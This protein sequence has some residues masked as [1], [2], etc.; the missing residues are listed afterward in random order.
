MIFSTR[1]IPY[2]K[3][4]LILPIWIQNSEYGKGIIPLDVGYDR[5]NSRLHQQFLGKN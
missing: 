2:R 1:I 4:L 5:Y 3:I